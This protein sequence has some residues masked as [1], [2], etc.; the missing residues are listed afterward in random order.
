MFEQPLRAGTTVVG[1]TFP[2]PQ[3]AEPIF[4]RYHNGLNKAGGVIM[5]QLGVLI[6]LTLSVGSAAAADLPGYPSSGVLPGMPSLYSRAHVW[7]GIY[8]GANAGGAFG[9]YSANAVFGPLSADLGSVKASGFIGGGQVGAQIQYGHFVYGV[10]ADFQGSSQDHSDTF[11]VLG[12]S[13]LVRES[14]PW[15]GTVR[16]RLGWATDNVLLYGTGGVAVVDGKLTASALGLTATTER[17]HIGWTAGAGLEWAFA[18]HWTAKVEYLY[19]DSGN[20]EIANVGGVRLNGRIQDNIVRA[21]L[22]YYLF[23]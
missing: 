15:F 7:T 8:I 6:A 14:M 13:V 10:E 12:T 21:G 11:N 18:P 1:F 16:G 5:R 4:S 23:N 20:I 3:V 17:T 2:L 19:L 9:N 22:N